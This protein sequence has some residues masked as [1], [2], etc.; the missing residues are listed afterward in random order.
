MFCCDCPKSCRRCIKG[1]PAQIPFFEIF[2]NC[3]QARTEPPLPH[4][5]TDDTTIFDVDTV[6]MQSL[7]GNLRTIPNGRTIQNGRTIPNG[8]TIQNGRTIPNRSMQE[9]PDSSAERSNSE[10]QTCDIS[11]DSRREILRFTSLK[12][13]PTRSLDEPPK[14]ADI[15]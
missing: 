8:R 3:T 11:F 12:P 4:S 9:E 5:R 7:Q 10:V 6:I 14:Y 2:C 13:I 15:M 1:S